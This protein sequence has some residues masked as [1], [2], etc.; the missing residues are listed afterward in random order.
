MAIQLED[1]HRTVA[2]A[3]ALLVG[4]A[5][6]NV[7]SEQVSMSEVP[8]PVENLFNAFVRTAY[9]NKE[10]EESV[11]GF[12]F[13]GLLDWALS[14]RYDQW[15]K[16][17]DRESAKKILEIIS[18]NLRRETEPKLMIVPVRRT[19]IEAPMQIDDFI[20]VPPQET[21]G[22]FVDTLKSFGLSPAKI[23]DGLFD[24]MRKTTGHNFTHRPLV[25]MPTDK[26]EYLLQEQFHDTFTKQLL[27]LL[28][29]F[30]IQCPS[31]M[32]GVLLGIEN[33]VLSDRIFSGVLF[34]LKTGEMMRLG[35]D[36]MG[37]ELSLGFELSPDRLEEFRRNGLDIILA[38]LRTTHSNLAG[39]TRNAL[40]FLSRA[41]DAEIRR[42]NL[43]AF[44]SSMIAL[45]ALFSRD[46]NTPLRATL[47]DSV[48]LLID[49]TVEAR[50]ATSRRMKKLYDFRSQIVHAGDENVNEQA[51]RDAMQFCARSLFEVLTLASGWG[52]ASEDRLFGE[53]D[54]RKFS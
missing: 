33:A 53:I 27:P 24:H 2:A 9:R 45:E 10:L 5:E 47:A 23:R 8:E 49:S 16:K 6:F 35:L 44:I 12:T 52:N 34:Q 39:R 42:D 51:L 3:E 25:I 18:W 20:V 43:A 14:S 41:R 22:R 36:R 13:W 7:T 28:R 32:S 37:G 21:E 19:R 26:D 4:L 31:Q 11:E 46:P 38:W 40:S 50:I 29:V 1:D 48:A 15:T 30:H 17:P 54:R